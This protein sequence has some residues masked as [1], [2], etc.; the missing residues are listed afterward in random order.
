MRLQIG[1]TVLEADVS[2]DSVRLN[3]G[4]VTTVFQ[5]QRLADGRIHVVSPTDSWTVWIDGG[6]VGAAGEAMSVRCLPPAGEPEATVH[7]PLTPP[8]P[9]TVV[10]I[11]VEDGERV[12]GGQ[13]LL[14]LVAMKTEITLSAPHA[15]CVSDLRVSVGQ[16]VRPG[17]RLLQVH[18]DPI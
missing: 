7:D 9:A 4:G 18:R 11:L 6:R 14:V 8:M 16:S 1:G 3:E 13:P 17:D 12:S 5:C 15:G 10:R 2:P